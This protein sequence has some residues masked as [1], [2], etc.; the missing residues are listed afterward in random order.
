MASSVATP[1]G[2]RRAGRAA[3]P[4]ANDGRARRQHRGTRRIRVD[5]MVITS[6]LAHR[7]TARTRN[8][9]ASFTTSTAFDAGAVAPPPHRG[10]V[11]PACARQRTVWLSVRISSGTGTRP[12][13]A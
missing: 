4:R 10:E 11:A 1:D 2:L 6:Y 8:S 5:G 9:N 12:P 7:A 3:L 13:S